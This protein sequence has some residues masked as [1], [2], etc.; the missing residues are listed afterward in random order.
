[1]T[2]LG[3]HLAAVERQNRRTFK[4]VLVWSG[5]GRHSICTVCTVP[6]LTSARSLRTD[7]PQSE[8]PSNQPPPTTTT[9]ETLTT[10]LRTKAIDS[11]FVQLT[12]RTPHYCIVPT[13]T[14]CLR[15]QYSNTTVP[16][17]CV[18]PRIVYSPGTN[19]IHSLLRRSSIIA[20]EQTTARAQRSIG[21]AVSA[22]ELVH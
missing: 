12:S 6:H 3:A 19:S 8:H 17:C 16:T 15:V 5:S 20:S 22:F 13:T 18:L 14:T 11:C 1:L 4:N 21:I 10:T 2:G 7:P 9:A